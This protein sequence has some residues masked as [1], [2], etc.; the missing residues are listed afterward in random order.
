MQAL[1]LHLN[2]WLG[3]AAGMPECNKRHATMASPVKCID[4]SFVLLHP[5][6]EREVLAVNQCQQTALPQL[7]R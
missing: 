7:A 1:W 4:R 2:V 5:E 3:E 6:G